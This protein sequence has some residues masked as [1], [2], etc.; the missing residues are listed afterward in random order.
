MSSRRQQILEAIAERLEA[1]A[2]DDG[3]DTD[4]GAAVHMGQIV[5]LAQN[6]PDA[7]ISIVMGDENAKFNGGKLIVDLPIEIHA[8][9]KADLDQ[10]YITIE[11]LLS[12]AKRAVELEDRTLGGVLPGHLQRLA[13]RTLPREPGSTTVGV[14]LIYSAT[15]GEQ[16][17]TP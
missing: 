15:Y 4:A 1:I 2:I 8:I 14:A 3:Y 5:E 7:V 6:D 12:D 11:Q 16:W 10:P 13:V 9:A 17:G